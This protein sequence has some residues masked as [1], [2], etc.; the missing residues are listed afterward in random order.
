MAATATMAMFAATSFAQYAL[1]REGASIAVTNL[2]H[3]LIFRIRQ[4]PLV[5][6]SFRLSSREDAKGTPHV[7]E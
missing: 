1:F 4:S 5:G 6:L 3:K 2:M 7:R